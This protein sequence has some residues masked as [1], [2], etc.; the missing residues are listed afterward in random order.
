MCL[1]GCKLEN[2]LDTLSPL[3][4]A[5]ITASSFCSFK[6]PAVHVVFRPVCDCY[7]KRSENQTFYKSNV[8]SITIKQT[9]LCPLWVCNWCF[10][11]FSF[12]LSIDRIWIKTICSLDL[13]C[14]NWAKVPR[15]NKKIWILQFRSLL[16]RTSTDVQCAKS[17]AVFF[18]RMDCL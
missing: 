8:Y 7:G 2:K 16:R 1:F 9:L 12:R 6:I 10:E 4:T 5:T 15:F 14:R 17:H 11:I 3:D 18:I 13:L